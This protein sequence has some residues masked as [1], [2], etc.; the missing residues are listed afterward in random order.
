[1][2]IVTD[3]RFAHDR[4]ALA[5]TLEALPD[6][7]V[8]V[9]RDAGTNPHHAVHFFRFD[10]TDPE[11][12]MAAL[13][14]D[15]TVRDATLLAEFAERRLG[16]IEFAA[17]TELLAPEVTDMGGYVL[18]ARALPGENDTAR[19]YERW[20]L[21]DHDAAQAIWHH[22]R[23]AGF[24]FEIRGL[25]RGERPAIGGGSLESLTAEQRRTL[26][27]AYEAGYFREPREAGLADLADELDISPSAV[28]GRLTRGLRALIGSTLV[29]EES[30]E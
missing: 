23:E 28:A 10:E 20:L 19:W 4:G 13:E 15:H 2:P 3:V 17:D 16:R 27:V 9:V 26:V 11:T 25:H 21:P 1:M 18:E 30:A 6:L 12:L 8:T 14:A 5:G 24:D 7:E 29:I 22:A